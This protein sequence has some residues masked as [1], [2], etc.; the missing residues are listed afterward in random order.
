PS[1]ADFKWTQAGTFLHELGHNLGLMHGGNDHISN[2]PNHLSVMSYAY[3]TG[4]IPIDVPNDQL[5]YLYDYARFSGP[6]LNE[7]SLN[8]NAGMGGNLFHDGI[9]Y[10][11]RWWLTPDFEN[12]QEVFDATSQVDWNN[13]GIYQTGVRF[14]LNQRFDDKFNTL[15]GGINEWNRLYYRG[16]QIAKSS[17]QT[18]MM[19][20]QFTYRCL[21]KPAHSKYISAS[22]NV[23]KVT[24]EDVQLKRQ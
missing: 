10:G 6:N 24:F 9:Y 19:P 8:E 21:D 16:G 15:R 22:K 12:Y 18:S 11:G 23:R 1:G 3:Q 17:N 2:K 7:N 4:G 5:Y 20:S 13:N 14:N